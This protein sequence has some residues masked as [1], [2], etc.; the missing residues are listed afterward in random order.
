MSKIHIK[1]DDFNK[2]HLNSKF[3]FNVSTVMLNLIYMTDTTTYNKTVFM[4][5]QMTGQEDECHQE[6]LFWMMSFPF[7]ELSG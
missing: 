7:L 2:G 3:K 4:A 6:W 1:I 5:G